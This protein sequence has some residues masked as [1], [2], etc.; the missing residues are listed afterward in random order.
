MRTNIV[1]GVIAAALAV[2]TTLELVADRRAF[3]EI[4]TVPRLFPGFTESNIHWVQISRVRPPDAN[5]QGQPPARE[6][7]T[8]ARTADGWTLAGETSLA[9]APAKSRKIEQDVLMRLREI[10]RDVKALRR[11]QATE[12]ELAAAGLTEET[13]T[14]VVCL[15][16]NQ[17]PMAELYV[18]KD[19]S[20][21]K[22]GADAVKG[23][24]VRRRNGPEDKG[25]KEIVLY[26]PD[27]HWWELPTVAGSWVDN[28]VHEIR[29]DEIKSCRLRNA[30]GE[31]AFEREGETG[32]K[33][34]SGP[35]S[36]GVPRSGEV[37]WV[38]AQFALLQVSRYVEPLAKHEDLGVLGLD[39]GEFE[40]SAT[41]TGGRT[42]TLWIGKKIPGA[43]ERYA[44][45]AGGN[46]VLAISEWMISAYEKD[47][48]DFFEPTA[49]ALKPKDPPADKPGEGKK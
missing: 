38:F 13:G 36:V 21:G 46:F 11:A 44:R 26:E 5:A 15:D 45:V 41:T 12:A 49:D 4:D 23:W 19:A 32:W 8:L 31:V 2:P 1:L 40:V 47:P 39:P 24:L 9:G 7:V 14:L 16:R 20:G 28:V 35:E 18:G 37:D 34:V 27:P 17:Q 6:S 22:A 33:T 42:H 48:K 43:P 29:I 10:P 3:T 25:P 30:K